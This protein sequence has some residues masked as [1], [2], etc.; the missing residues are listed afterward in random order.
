VVQETDFKIRHQTMTT[1]GNLTLWSKYTNRKTV[2]QLHIR[3]ETFPS[4]FL[5]QFRGFQ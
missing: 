4:I 3:C 2:F 5:L 1:W